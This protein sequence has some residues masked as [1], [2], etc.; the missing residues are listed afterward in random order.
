M[1]KLL[2]TMALTLTL[3]GVSAPAMADSVHTPTP[4]PTPTTAALPSWYDTAPPPAYDTSSNPS[5]HAGDSLTVANGVVTVSYWGTEGDAPNPGQ[6]D[7]DLKIITRSDDEITVPLNSTS[8]A[9]MVTR[10]QDLVALPSESA[11]PQ[12]TVAMTPGGELTLMRP[13]IPASC[14]RTE[15]PQMFEFSAAA[16]GADGTR[17]LVSV[18]VTFG[19]RSDQAYADCSAALYPQSSETGSGSAS[20]TEESGASPQTSKVDPNSLWDSSSYAGWGEPVATNPLTDF[21]RGA[22]LLLGLV[23]LALLAFR[24]WKRRGKPISTP[25]PSWASATGASAA[26][27]ASPAPGEHVDEP[28]VPLFDNKGNHVAGPTPDAFFSAN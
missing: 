5:G 20:G 10:F 18:Q 3:A 21:V 7:V 26:Y 28:T 27:A 24:I 13:A 23:L 11:D 2:T 4:E 22:V 16:L 19:E 9:R 25:V 15:D 17:Y 6:S 14:N 8:F 1:Q 12:P